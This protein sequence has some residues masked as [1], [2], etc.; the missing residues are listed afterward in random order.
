MNRQQQIECAAG[1]RELSVLTHENIPV[2]CVLRILGVQAPAV[3]AAG[4]VGL[5]EYDAAA[6][7]V[8]VGCGSHAL[9]ILR[10]K[11]GHGRQGFFCFKLIAAVG[12][13]VRTVEILGDRHG[14]IQRCTG[15]ER[16]CLNGVAR[17]FGA[18][19]CNQHDDENQQHQ[20][21]GGDKQRH[22]SA[23]PESL[24]SSFFHDGSSV[25]G[26]ISSVYIYKP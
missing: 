5:G 20:R 9:V 15:G 19:P 10:D 13:K 14:Q 2:L 6:V 26:L 3:C 7:A 12:D 22:I 25:S 21:C 16:L 17:G 23:E 1:Q 4:F 24:L 8:V 11:L 18:A